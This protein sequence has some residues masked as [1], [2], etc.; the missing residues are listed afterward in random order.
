[1]HL[2][3]KKG[4]CSLPDWTIIRQWRNPTLTL[5]GNDIFM[6]SKGYNSTESK[7][8]CPF[9]IL[10]HSSLISISVQNFKNSH[11]KLLKLKT[12]NKAL[13]DEQTYKQYN[14]LSCHLYHVA[15][16]KN[17]LYTCIY[18]KNKMV[19][20]KSMKKDAKYKNLSPVFRTDESYSK[21]IITVT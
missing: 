13:T 16:Y 10:N 15:E 3:G 12:G 1:M 21:L 8:N 19:P 2:G 18:Y 17:K 4:R 20:T 5:D 9:T 11:L 14:I 7:W 6:S